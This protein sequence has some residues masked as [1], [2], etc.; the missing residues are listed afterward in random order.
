MSQTD[1]CK[2]CGKMKY[3]HHSSHGIKRCG[4]FYNSAHFESQ[5]DSLLKDLNK[6]E[7]ALIKMKYAK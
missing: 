3:E 6:I 4:P 7:K 5:N 1:I 2:V